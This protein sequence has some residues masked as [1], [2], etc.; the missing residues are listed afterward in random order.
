MGFRIP[1]ERKCERGCLAVDSESAGVLLAA[2][3]NECRRV[4]FG[5]GDEAEFFVHSS[6]ARPTL[7][8]SVACVQLSCTDV[9][10]FTPAKQNKPNFFKSKF[11]VFKFIFDFLFKF[12]FN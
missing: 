8:A 6:C 7:A 11:L 4:S 2:K 1:W 10:L 5:V 12:V 3:G 9:F